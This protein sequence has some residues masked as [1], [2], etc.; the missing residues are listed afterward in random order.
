MITVQAVSI[1]QDNT[2]WVSEEYLKGLENFIMTRTVELK[3]HI[4]AKQKATELLP[5]TE[6]SM[7]G[8]TG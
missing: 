1:T 3:T 6:T 4:P 8:D 7:L 2:L 5:M